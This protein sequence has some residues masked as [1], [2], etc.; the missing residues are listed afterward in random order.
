M[1]DVSVVSIIGGSNVL[2][3]VF[4]EYLGSGYHQ[5]LIDYPNFDLCLVKRCLRWTASSVFGSLDGFAM[6]EFIVN[7][8]KD[9][10]TRDWMSS[11]PTLWKA[12][13]TND[14]TRS[15]LVDVAVIIIIVWPLIV[16]YLNETGRR[17]DGD[18]FVV[19]P[20]SFL[21]IATISFPHNL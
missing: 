7:R 16:S 12:I 14:L 13:L 8:L 18:S 5:K 11:H 17:D 21:C 1:P 9:D 15:Y 3:E 4:C 10:K 2:A 6:T 20:S 19:R